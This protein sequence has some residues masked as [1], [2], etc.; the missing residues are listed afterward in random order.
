M[1][2]AW[3]ADNPPPPLDGGDT[4]AS[5]TLARLSAAWPEAESATANEPVAQ[6]A[7]TT[8]TSVGTEKTDRNEGMRRL[9]ERRHA[10][11]VRFA[12]FLTG[13]VTAAEDVA[14]DAFAKVFDAWESIDDLERVDAYL[15]STV[16][17]LVRGGQ[18]RQQVAE[19][20]ATPHLTV[21]PSA[22]DDAV[23]RIGRERVLA[24]VAELPLRQRACVVM[25][26]WMRMTETEI[27]NVLELSVG[28]VRTHIKRGT[29]HLKSSLGD[30]R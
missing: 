23:G 29:A 10:D 7:E 19:R 9:Y 15:K 4:D 27:A 26:H 22:E 24:A 16:V 28:S 17:N 30:Q 20:N 11:M 6:A 21:V 18:R 25:R 14:Q 8:R 3:T 13:D 2:L 12:A 1:K 5:P